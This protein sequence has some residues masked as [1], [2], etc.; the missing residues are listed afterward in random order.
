MVREHVGFA[1]LVAAPWVAV[2]GAVSVAYGL[3]WCQE[4]GQIT[5]GASALAAA[6]TA[7]EIA[8]RLLA[9]PGDRSTAPRHP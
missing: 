1:A 8:W 5:S 6:L 3:P 2:G 7:G 4:A 9:N